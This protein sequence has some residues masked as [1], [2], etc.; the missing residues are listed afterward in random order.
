MKKKVVKKAVPKP[1]AAKVPLGKRPP[2]TTALPPQQ[3]KKG[4]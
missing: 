3:I 4:C 2:T 1:P